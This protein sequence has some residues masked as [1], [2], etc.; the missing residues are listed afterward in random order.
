MARKMRRTQKCK[1]TPCIPVTFRLHVAT[2]TDTCLDLA[3]TTGRGQLG[4]KLGGDGNDDVF[5]LHFELCQTS[6]FAVELEVI[7]VISVDLRSSNVV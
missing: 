1:G 3:D 6:A 4:T 5:Q 2:Q 7:S